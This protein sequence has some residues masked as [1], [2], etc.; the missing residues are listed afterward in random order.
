MRDDLLFLY[1]RE[2]TYLRRLGGEFAR[3]Y[4]KVASRLQL[5]EGKCEDPHVERLLEGFAFLTARVHLRLDDDF[6]EVTSTLLDVVHPNYARPLPSMSIAEFELD[7]EQGKPTTGYRIPRGSALVTRPVNGVRCRFR[8]V[9][10]TTLWPIT[11]ADAQWTTPDRLKPPRKRADAVA[12]LRLAIDCLPDVSFTT[13]ELSTLRFHLNGDASLTSALYELLANN[14]IAIEVRDVSP[15]ATAPAITLPPSALR[16]VGFEPDESMLPSARQ[17]FAGYGLLHEYF[18]F[19]EKFA[20]FEL[21]GLEALRSH[22]MGTQVEVVFLCSAFERS[23]RR[24]LLESSVSAA[25]FRLG[26]APVVNLFEQ[27]AEPIELSHQQYEHLIVPNARQRG[28]F[29]VFSVDEVQGSSAGSAD[30]VS[31]EPMY[32]FRHARVGTGDLL[33]KATRRPSTWR[34]DDGTDMWLAFADLSGQTLVPGV[35]Q[36]TCRLT[37]FNGDLPSRLPFGNDDGDFELVAGGPLRRI[38]ALVK[39][40]PVQ[41]PPLGQ[42]QMW[43]LISLFSLKYVSV[44]DAGSDGMRELLRLFAGHAPTGVAQVSGVTGFTGRPVVSRVSTSHGI[45]FARGHRLELE[46]DEEA[47]A[48]SGAFLFASVLERFLGLYASLN[49]FSQLAVRTRQRKQWLKEW[50]PRAGWKAL[51]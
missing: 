48:G 31:F 44:V 17:A 23:E 47:F 20:A 12:A 27:V 50:E 18:A 30:A 19:P 40:T 15:R 21:T 3:K 10:D 51:I 26:C 16:P 5:E 7:P 4:P 39:P 42:A 1:E 37:C 41:Y 28:A 34:A 22:T 36:V 13:L 45:A 43:R 33:W 29:E 49:S 24:Q 46:L 25:T 35:E 14:C 6:P 8:T 11:I 2:L 38:R 32:S 9:Y